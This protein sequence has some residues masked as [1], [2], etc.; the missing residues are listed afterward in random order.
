MASVDSGFSQE[1]SA[2]TW[3]LPCRCL[4]ANVK[5]DSSF[6]KVVDEFDESAAA[7][8]GDF[9]VEDYLQSRE[10]AL[11][12]ALSTRVRATSSCWFEWRSCLADRHRGFGSGWVDVFVVVAQGA[13]QV[14]EVV[15]VEAVV[16][17]SAAAPD[18]DDAALSQYA[19]LV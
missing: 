8:V 2:A 12:E 18:C 6:A 5:V 13:E 4:L 3:E 17:V 10:Q 7:A 11:G 16:R 9:D 1:G 14:G 19:Q 15:V